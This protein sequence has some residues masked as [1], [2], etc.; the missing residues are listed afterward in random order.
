MLMELLMHAIFLKSDRNGRGVRQL[1]TDT[2]T[3]REQERKKIDRQKGK[4]E[5][6]YKH[7]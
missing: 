2:W 3:S 5:Y 7:R 4:K 6:R 1:Q